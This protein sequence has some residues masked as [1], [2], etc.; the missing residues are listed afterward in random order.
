MEDKKKFIPVVLVSVAITLLVVAIALMLNGKYS[1]FNNSNN[2][3]NKSDNKQIQLEDNKTSENDS[4]DDIKQNDIIPTPTPVPSPIPTNTP[5][6]TPSPIPSSTPNANSNSNNSNTGNSSTSNSTVYTEN[7]VISYFQNGE[8]SIST[9]Q[10]GATFK[11]KAKNTFVTIVDFIF[12][13]KEIK[14]HTFKELSNS[15][16]LQII[17]IALS[18]DSKIEKYF[19]DYKETIKTKYDN[20]KG[21]LASLYLEVVASLCDSVGE[22]TCNQAK[23]DFNTMKSSFG[24]TWDL[25]KELA[26]SGKNKVK[27]FYESWRDSE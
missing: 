13:D 19:P 23:E 22:D 11:E 14:G 21:K 5:V 7:D 17:K 6:N 10:E 9:Y 26:V 18:I 20:L 25:I 1:I 8:N 16:K 12:Y 24:F 4:K 27:D 15:A 2:L 3:E